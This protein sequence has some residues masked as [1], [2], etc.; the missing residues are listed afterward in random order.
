MNEFIKE[1]IKN[2]NLI[3]F[4]KKVKFFTCRFLNPKFVY[5]ITNQNK[6]ISDIY[7]LDRGIAI[8]RFYIEKFLEENKTCIRGSCLELLNNN[9]T[10]KY[11]GKNVLKSDVLDIEKDNKEANIIGDLRDLKKIIP[12]NSYDC[13]ILT[14]VLQFIDDYNLALLEC[15]R[16]LKPGGYLLITAPSISR[17][18]CVAGVGGDFWRFTKASLNYILNDKFSYVNVSSFGN[19]NIGASFLIGLSE[20]DISKHSYNLNDENFPILITAVVTK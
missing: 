1:K 14:Q 9:Y 7:G 15:K 13:I 16:I 6:P 12:D 19:V 8:D 2:K 10:I 5:F 4:F 18:D 11:G 3:F 17:I 20:Q